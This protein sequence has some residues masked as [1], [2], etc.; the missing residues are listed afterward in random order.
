M[1]GQHYRHTVV[2]DGAAVTEEII[3]LIL[4]VPDKKFHV[5]CR[6]E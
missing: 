1:R 5:N 2:Q 4:A 3:I 6:V